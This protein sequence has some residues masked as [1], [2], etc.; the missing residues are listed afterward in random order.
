M[1]KLYTEGDNHVDTH[2]AIVL[3]VSYVDSFMAG[4]AEVH[5]VDAWVNPGTELEANIA[6]NYPDI[7]L[8]DAL[9]KWLDAQDAGEDF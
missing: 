1:A 8:A 7:Y 4:G 3:H 2:P 5:L 9:E 6:Y